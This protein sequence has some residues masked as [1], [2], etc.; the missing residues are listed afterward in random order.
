[1][2]I[3][4]LETQR[5]LLR[6]FL[7]EDLDAYA[8]M[9]GDPEV[10][11]YIGTGKPLSRWESWRSMATM[12][13]HWQLRQYG[14][15]AVE[16]RQNGEMIGRIGCWKPEGWPGFEIGWTLRRQY[17][18]RGFATEGA[19][20]A[21][22]YAFNVLQQSRVISLIRPQNTASIR[23]AQKLGEKLEG[24]TEIFGSEA[25]IYSIGRENW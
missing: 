21:I 8:E 22:D 5:L 17:W 18:G 14:M 12:L 16:E 1:M 23:V 2:H 13:G 10:M 3:P 6:G 4:Q 7:E 25:V 11:R 24:T 19:T 15:W 20:A 9:C